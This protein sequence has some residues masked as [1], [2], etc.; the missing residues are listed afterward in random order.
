MKYLTS[1]TLECYHESGF[2]FQRAALADCEISVIFAAGL[3]GDLV[4]R[5]SPLRSSSFIF[6]ADGQRN[7]K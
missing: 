3:G 4:R 7:I 5:N 6:S 1:M 2:L